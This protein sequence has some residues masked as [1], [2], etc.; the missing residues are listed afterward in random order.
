MFNGCR[1][2]GH[3]VF[4][5]PYVKGCS[6]SKGA[7][8][9]SITGRPRPAPPYGAVDSPAFSRSPAYVEVGLRSQRSVMCKSLVVDFR[10]I[11]LGLIGPETS[12]G[13]WR[14][15]VSCKVAPRGHNVDH[16]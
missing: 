3:V 5:S 13:D 15:A 16:C 7:K 6:F 10:F 11:C 12:L 8:M 1:F 4:A 2:K 14:K 9:I